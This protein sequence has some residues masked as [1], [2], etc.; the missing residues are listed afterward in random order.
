MEISKEVHV[1]M[2]WHHPGQF[3]AHLMN[4]NITALYFCGEGGKY[5]LESI[6]LQF[7]HAVHDS[8]S[9]LFTMI[10]AQHKE[11]GHSFAGNEAAE[12]ANK[13]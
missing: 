12:N 13:T 4:G 8:L 9:D 2:Q 10:D 3:T 5:P 7:L 1:E 11:L 6:D